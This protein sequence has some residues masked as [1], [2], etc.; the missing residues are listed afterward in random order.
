MIAMARRRQRQRIP[1]QPDQESDD[2][3]KRKLLLAGGG[4]AVVLV[5]VL[6][7]LGGGGGDPEPEWGS[8]GS[9]LTEYDD[10]KIVADVPNATDGQGRISGD[11]I[12]LTND[13]ATV[14]TQFF[15]QG[16]YNGEG[17]NGELRRDDSVVMEASPEID[18]DDGVVQAFMVPKLFER[19]NET[20]INVSIY[21][22]QEFMDALDRDARIVWG[23]IPN[24][25]RSFQGTE[26][27]DGLY[28]DNVIIRGAQRMQYSASAQPEVW[29]GDF[30]QFPITPEERQ[31]VTV[32]VMR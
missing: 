1:G 22:D 18:P 23:W 32:V 11:S 6:V 27:R 20:V 10:G 9:G 25:S 8:P 16:A 30:S 14:G 26:I 17:F 3:R 24:S 28:A 29:V 2:A 15:F 12:M 7:L 31:S 5:T 19:G 13:R 4:V 21:L